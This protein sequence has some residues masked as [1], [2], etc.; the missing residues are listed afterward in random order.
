M[1]DYYS[2]RARYYPI[3]ILFFP[4]V[5]LGAFYSLEFESI[6][7]FI[8]SLGVLGALTYLFS[9]LGRDL[10]KQKEPGLW[11]HWGG[12]PSIQLL[13]WKNDHFDTYTKKR[14]HARLNTLC[15]V[16]NTPDIALETADS[17]AS[18]E[19]YR[20]WCKYIIS[21]TR[22][23]R[24]FNLLFKENTN[25]G[26]RRNLWG[27]RTVALWLIMVLLLCNYCVWLIKLNNFNPLVYPTNYFYSTGALVL[28]LFFWMIVVNRNWVRGVA[29]AYAD[30]LCEAVDLI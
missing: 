30:R 10:G 20:A 19:I 16:G 14:Y 6:S 28:I 17:K 9:Q 3:V 24:K 18:D 13:R 1:F 11:R 23:T 7:H 27:L 21:Q 4:V 22:D 25:Y 15:P 8:G 5:I 29:F 2:L 12:M 26:F